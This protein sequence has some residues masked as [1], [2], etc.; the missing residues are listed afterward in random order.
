MDWKL[1]VPELSFTNSFH[2]TGVWLRKWNIDSK[3]W[4]CVN[5]PCH[6]VT[7]LNFPPGWDSIP[8]KSQTTIFHV[9]DVVFHHPTWFPPVETKIQPPILRKKRI[10][11]RILKKKL[12]NRPSPS[13]SP[14]PKQATLVG[15]VR[16]VKKKQQDISLPKTTSIGPMNLQGS[17]LPPGWPEGNFQD[18]RCACRWWNIPSGKSDVISSCCWMVLRHLV[19]MVWRLQVL[20]CLF[21]NWTRFCWKVGSWRCKFFGPFFFDKTSRCGTCWFVSLAKNNKPI[22]VFITWPFIPRI[23]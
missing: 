9:S 2:F 11:T 21:P 6:F 5:Y 13:P 8:F 1:E 17:T 22:G 15:K 23:F 10:S 14:P 4:K 16:S 18:H 3:L 12:K 19:W 7:I 20:F